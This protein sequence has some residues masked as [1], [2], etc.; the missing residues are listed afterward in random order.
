MPLPAGKTAAQGRYGLRRLREEFLRAERYKEP[1]SLMIAAADA[2]V[3]VAARPGL[4]AEVGRELE[5]VVRAQ[6][7]LVREAEDDLMV[8]LPNT[9]FVG[10]LSIA[11]RTLRE[12]GA[13]DCES[14]T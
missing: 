1:L 4:L 9:H 13:H 14:N 10:S 5:R 11:E 12:L 6:D 3:P 7:L 2:A 8:L